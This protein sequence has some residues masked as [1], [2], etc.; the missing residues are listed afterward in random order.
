MKFLII[1]LLEA[2]AWPMEAP[3][4]YSAFHLG[5][6]AAGILTAFLLAR[7]L[8]RTQRPVKLL[9]ICGLLLAL[10]EVYKQL[11]LYY[12]VNG[13]HYDWCQDHSSTTPNY[14]ER[15][16]WVDETVTGY[17]CSGCGE[18]TQVPY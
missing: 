6:T 14:R 12:I 5:L 4:P 16:V 2:S 10:S 13:G 3:S 11:F 17:H 9:F 18:S 1:H 7:R 15:D 8:S